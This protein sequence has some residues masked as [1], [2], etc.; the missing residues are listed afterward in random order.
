MANK[1]KNERQVYNILNLKN[2]KHSQ[3]DF[4]EVY[5]HIRTNIEYSTVDKDICTIA[6]TSTQPAE[7]KSITALNLSIIFATKYKKVLLIDCDLRKSQLHKYFKISNKTGLTDALISSSKNKVIESNH[8]QLIDDESFAGPLT[9]LTSGT[10]VPNPTEILSSTTFKIFIETLKRQY[11]YIILD[12]PPSS[13]SDIIPIGN[14]ADGTL[15][16]CSSLDTNRKQAKAAVDFLLQNN[17]NILGSILTKA[18]GSSNHY[19]YYY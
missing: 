15:F 6:I 2:K 17:V 18:E 13:V 12:C 3:F 19:G 14:I 16:V 4:A 1:R 10:S 11:D 5:R 8:F 7:A 9:I